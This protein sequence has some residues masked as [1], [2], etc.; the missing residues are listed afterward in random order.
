[1]VLAWDVDGED[2]VARR[3]ATR[4]AHAT[5]IRAEWE[6]GHV[7]LG[8][9]ILDDDGTVRGS[10]VIVEYPSRD[11]VDR[12]LASEPFVTESVWERIEVHPLRVPDF[13]LRR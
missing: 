3:D 11:D 2:G 4:P 10:L 13:Y 12:Y 7:L 1:M 9:G 6:A 8:A 5:S